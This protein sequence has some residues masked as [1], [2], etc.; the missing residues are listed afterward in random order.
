[1][2]N[3]EKNKQLDRDFFEQIWN[4]GYGS[5]IDR[6]VAEDATGNDTK[7]GVGRGSFRLRWHKWCEAF[8]DINFAF[9]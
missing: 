6:V 7:F 8:S 5:A 2:P 4:Q 9:A 3:S 1:M